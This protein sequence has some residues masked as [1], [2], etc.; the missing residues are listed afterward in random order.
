M[1]TIVTRSGKGSAL[2]HTEADANFT[3]LN[4]DKLEGV[5]SSTANAIVRWS[6]TGGSTLQNTSTTT[7]N[8]NGDIVVGGTT[9]TITLGD[10]GAEDAALVYDGNAKDFY[11]AL[12]DTADKLLIG[13]GSTVGTNPILTITDD[14]VTIGDGAAVDT[15][16]VFDGNAKDFHIALDDTADK[17]IIGEGSTV[18]TNEILSITDDSVTIGDGATEDTY[19]NFDGNAVDFRIGIDDGTDKLEVGAGTAHGSTTAFTIDS[20]ANLAVGVKLMMPDVTAGKILVG[21]GTSYE[22]VAVSGDIG[23]ASTGAATIQSTSVESGMVNTN[24]ITGQ[25]EETSVADGDFLLIYDASA[26]AFRK[27][28]KSNL[29]NLTTA[30]SVNI[31]T[32]GD[33]FS[34]YDTISSTVT[35]TVPSNSNG[36]LMGPMTVGSGYSWT[37][38]SGS[39]INIL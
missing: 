37:I 10:G 17:L 27:M 6:G 18:G 32:V 24:V 35:T 11:I 13:E 4:T 33:E 23:L 29:V 19:L 2:T 21:D 30:A 12:D 34:N 14:T 31:T 28:Q 25:T 1:A 16:I 7:I 8:D 5:S 22:E 38:A 9:P 26:T 3:N 20:S 15:A 36:F 39:T